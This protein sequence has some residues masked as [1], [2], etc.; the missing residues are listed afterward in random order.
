MRLHIAL[1]ILNTN[2]AIRNKERNNSINKETNLG[3]TYVN[4]MME[5]KNNF[6]VIL[7]N[8][9][10]K[11]SHILQEVKNKKAKILMEKD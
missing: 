4:T 5:T 1:L 7:K 8:L 11:K 9:R 10:K 6:F 2:K 3:L